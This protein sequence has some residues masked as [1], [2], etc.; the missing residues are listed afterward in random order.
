MCYLWPMKTLQYLPT[1]RT[2]A[3]FVT[4]STVLTLC[5]TG[6]T[7][8][9]E[10]TSRFLDAR[11]AASK[12]DRNRLERL[13]SQ[14]GNHPLDVYVEYWWLGNLLA[15]NDAMARPLIREFLQRQQGSYLAERLRSDW[16]RRLAR[17]GDWQTVQQEYPRLLQPEQD[18]RCIALQGKLVSN[19]RDAGL[20][21]A[22][23]LWLAL[24]EAVD[25]C[26][27]VLRTLV[28]AGKV[29]IDD[30]Y[31]RIRRLHEHK[32]FAA[33]RELVGWLNHPDLPDPAAL[34]LAASQAAS[35]LDRL[36]PN[37]AV[38]RP[39]REV[40]LL[41]LGRLAQDDPRQAYQR[42]LRLQDRLHGHER[43]YAL[44]QIAWQ[45]ARRLLPEANSWY[46]AAGDQ[47]MNADQRAWKIRAALRA[48]DW[49]TV[50]LAIEQM[51]LTERDAPEWAYWYGR[52]LAHQGRETEARRYYEGITGNTGFYSLLAN[53]ELGR[54]F[55]IP[56]PAAQD[57]TGRAERHPGIQRALSL[58]R[59]DLR[60]EGT[61]EWNWALRGQ[62]DAFL[63]AAARLAEQQGLYD[64]MIWAADRTRES[65][66][67]QL[68][69]P[70]PWRQQIEPK[71]REQGLDPGWVYGL[72]RQESRFVTAAKS[73][74][75]AQGLMQVMPATG[76][77]VA[78]QLGLKDYT[79][80]WLQDPER[81]VLL[82]TNYMR[83]VLSGLDRHPVLASAA[84]NAGPGRAKRWKDAK[85]LEGA[86]YA[87]T[88]P[89]TE[90]R[91]YVKKVMANS[92][93]YGALFQGQAP[94]L[95]ERLGVI[96]PRPTGELDD[97]AA[98]G[99]GLDQ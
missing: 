37:F 93:V 1:R 77:W 81:N 85:P 86:I 75:G 64:R 46:K 33:A 25:S 89:F 27:P 16:L 58:F 61:R 35:W 57:G 3:F 11:D 55:S 23:P 82:G 29:D 60:L 53:E 62:D 6:L 78:K 12:G 51:P 4:I 90:T 96:A 43:S 88:I 49:K 69:Y 72:M 18:M 95:K 19:D 32:R 7:H 8:A 24:T 5:C 76:K 26:Q 94:S 15:R 59:L 73:T 66:D 10:G 42:Y 21:E 83:I 44:G 54:R 65:H 68:R 22:R 31:A 97:S 45:A 74:V 48:L 38:Q 34:E 92:V 70:T 9:Q 2:G 20:A 80:Q 56:T 36:A 87:E 79:P 71:A 14:V 41:A 91:D 47:P 67:Y 98:P 13:A 39:L 30:V 63:L 28:E 52:A 50:R 40:T 17:E 99:A 84:Y